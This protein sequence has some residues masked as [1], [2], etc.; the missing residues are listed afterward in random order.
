MS[1]CLAGTRS[2]ATDPGAS[3][4]TRTPAL[5]SRASPTTPAPSSGSI[6]SSPSSTRYPAKI[7]NAV[8]APV[9]PHVYENLERKHNL[10][11][12]RKGSGTKATAL[13]SEKTAEV[14]NAEVSTDDMITFWNTFPTSVPA[15]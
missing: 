2:S 5:A 10:Y 13:V 8:G 4:A 14:S 12:A 11:L 7:Q 1:R 3:T 6:P 9:P 15:P